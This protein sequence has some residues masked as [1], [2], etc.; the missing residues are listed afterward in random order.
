MRQKSEA[1]L[2]KIYCNMTYCV[3][4]ESPRHNKVTQVLNYSSG[5]CTEVWKG[6]L[7][8][9]QFYSYYRHSFFNWLVFHSF[10][11]PYSPNVFK[12]FSLCRSQTSEIL[13]LFKMRAF[14]SAAVRYTCQ[15]LQYNIHA[16][17]FGETC[18]V[19]MHA[20][21][22]KADSLW[23][24]QRWIQLRWLLPQFP[25][26]GITVCPGYVQLGT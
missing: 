26:H 6:S 12:L 3:Y 10:C 21:S 25:P 22:N 16:L 23:V 24:W 14:N 8:H 17:L 4:R 19:P 9:W 5:T 11:K 18:E 1:K 15:S 20:T 7:K 2:H 13:F